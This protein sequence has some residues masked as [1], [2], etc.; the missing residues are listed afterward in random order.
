[1]GW[2]SHELKLNRIK[3]EHLHDTRRSDVTSC[4][5][6]A[7]DLFQ[8]VFDRV[9]VVSEDGPRNLMGRTGQRVAESHSLVPD[10]SEV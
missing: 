5:P 6:H 7:F 8:H 10:C 9:H 4:V 2:D 1:M 3:S